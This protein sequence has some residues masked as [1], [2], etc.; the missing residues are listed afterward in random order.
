MAHKGV[1]GQFV[2]L[3][4]GKEALFFL[5]VEVGQHSPHEM[6]DSDGGDLAE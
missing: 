5:V 2:V 1:L 3:V 6:V 4:A